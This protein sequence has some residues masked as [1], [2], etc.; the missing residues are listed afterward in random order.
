LQRLAAQVCVPPPAS[1][2]NHQPR[3][4]SES[5]YDVPALLP[6]TTGTVQE[7]NALHAGFG[8]GAGGSTQAV[9]QQPV[10]KWIDGPPE[11]HPVFRVYLKSSNVD[12]KG[13]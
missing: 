11:V 7:G 4:T 12:H 13:R 8:C 9:Q 1:A 3:P 6:E 10:S 5:F 2:V